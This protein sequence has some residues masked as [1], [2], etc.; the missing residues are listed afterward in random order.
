MQDSLDDSMSRISPAPIT[1]EV[2]LP[3]VGEVESK[4]RSLQQASRDKISRLEV[5]RLQQVAREKAVAD[6]VVGQLGLDPNDTFGALANRGVATYTG[7]ANGAGALASGAANEFA[8][9]NRGLVD[10]LVQQAYQREQW[11][12]ANAD[13]RKLL[14]APT[15]DRTY[16]SDAD[17]TERFANKIDARRAEIA[18][19]VAPNKEGIQPTGLPQM[20]VDGGL[21]L[22]KGAIA[23]P[24]AAVGVASMFSGGA[25]GKYL[26]DAGFRPAEAKDFVESM[27]SAELQAA[28]QSVNGAEDFWSTVDQVA[29]NPSAAGHILLESIFPMLAGGLLARGLKALGMGVK[30][31]TAA[32]EGAL[33]A[34]SSA[35]QIRGQTLDKRLSL[36]QSLAAAT[37]GVM[38]GTV[39]RLS[40]GVS[41]RLGLGDI[42]EAITKG[43]LGTSQRGVLARTG[44]ATAFESAEEGLQSTG[45]TM[46]QNFALD[47]AL[48]EGV[49]NA[50]ALG[51]VTGA[52]MGAPMGLAKGVGEAKQRYQDATKLQDEA[53]A[54]GDVTALA[55]PAARTYAPERAIA[56]LT[57]NA[58]LATTTEEAKQAHLAKADEIVGVLDKKRA[59]LGVDFRNTTLK[60]VTAKIAEM[61]ALLA[62]T[63]PAKVDKIAGYTRYLNGLQKELSLLE[64]DKTEGKRTKSLEKEIAT[65]DTQI[66]GVNTAKTQLNQ[67]VQGGTG[68]EAM[69]AGLSMPADPTDL[70]A[71]KAAQ[72]TATRTVNLAMSAPQLLDP[73]R[74]EEVAADMTNALTAPQRLVLREFSKARLEQNLL[75]S[76]GDVSRQIYEGGGGNTGIKTYQDRMAVAVRTGNQK[77]AEEQLDGLGKFEADHR[78]KAEVAAAAMAKGPGI[79]IINANGQWQIGDGSLSQSQARP[80]GALTINS[81]KL[82]SDI[83]QEAAALTASLSYLTKAYE[84]KFNAPAADASTLTGAENVTN[85]SQQGQG[86]QVQSKTPATK[87]AAPTGGTATSSEGVPATVETTGGV[88]AAGVTESAVVEAKS[89]TVNEETSVSSV[90]TDSTGVDKK[91]EITQN[92][93][94]T[95]STE[96]TADTTVETQA[97]SENSTVESDTAKTI[98]SDGKLSALQQTSPEGT[99]YKLR[100]NL[101]GDFFKQTEGR[102]GD[103][104]LRPLVAVSNFMSALRDKTVDLAD[105]L[106]EGALTGD[107]E[108]VARKT[109]I[110]QL[111]SKAASTWSKTLREN[112]AQR[113]DN[114]KEYFFRDLM[115][116][117]LITGQDGKPDLEENVKTA[118]SY[119][120]FSFITESAGK[121]F[122]NDPE[123]INALLDRDENHPVSSEETDLLGLVGDRRNTVINTLGQRAIQ[124]LGLSLKAKVGANE[125]ARLES[126]LGAH[127]WKMMVDQGLMEDTTVSG[128]EMSELIGKASTDENASFHFTRLAR[129]PESQA[130]NTAAEQIFQASRKTQGILD[131]MF[132]VESALKEPSL[133][134]V[135]AKQ[136][137]AKNTSQK[138]PSKLKEIMARQNSVANYVRQE[139]WHLIGS[140]DPGIAMQIAGAVDTD[141][142]TTHKANRLANE[143]KNEGLRRELDRFLDFVGLMDDPKAAMFFE[144]VVFKQQRVGINGNV[145]NPQT[146]KVARH[147]LYQKSWETVVRFDNEAEVKNLQLRIA[148]GLGVKA[149]KQSN[150]SS[151]ADYADIVAQPEIDA[152]VKVLQIDRKGEDLTFEQQDVL[153]AGVKAGG[154]NMASLDALVALAEMANAIVDNKPSVTVYLMGEV[155]GVTNGP[156]LSHLL[157]GAADTAKGLFGLL[158]RGGFFEEGSKHSNYNLWRGDKTEGNF[159]LYESTGKHMITAAQRL[160]TTG[161]HNAQGKKIMDGGWVSQVLGAIYTFTG[162]LSDESPQMLKKR[163]NIIK[164]PLTAMVFGSSVFSAVDSMANDFIGAIYA[165]I[166][167]MAANDLA[168]EQHRRDLIENINVLLS[169]GNAPWL[170]T[171]LTMADLMEVEFSKE[172]T[173]ALKKAF[174]STLGEAVKQTMEEDFEN[175]IGKR[176]QFNEAA[177]L[178]FEIYNAAYEA[179]RDVLIAKLVAD[180]T[181][182]ATKSGEAVHELSAEQEAQLQEQLG[183]LQPLI[184]TPLSR[185]TGELN[186]GL[187]A[188]KTSKRLSDK[189]SRASEIKF[190]KGVKGDGVWSKLKKQY[191]EKTSI[192]VNGF[193]SMEM[194]PGVAMLVMMIHS[195]DSAIMHSSIGDTEVLNVHDAKGVG[196]GGFQQAAQS[197]NASVWDVLVD[198]SPANEMVGMLSRTINGLAVLVKDDKLPLE[199]VKAVAK[200]LYTMS[201]K[202][203]IDPKDYL[204]SALKGTQQMAFEADS[205]KLEAMAMM[206]AI[207]QYA[208]QGGQYAVTK[209][210]RDAARAKMAALTA[211]VSPA[212]QASA[213]VIAEL[214]DAEFDILFKEATS[215]VVNEFAEPK[216]TP[217]PTVTSVF[218]PLGTPKIA[219]DA[220]LVEFFEANPEASFKRVLQGLLRKVS[221]DGSI[222]NP[223]F[224]TMLIKSLVKLVDPELKVKYITKDSPGDLPINGPVMGARGW[225]AINGTKQE[226]YVL[227]PEFVDSGLTTELLIHELVHAALSNIVQSTDKAVQ[228]FIA[229]LNE[230][231]KAAQTTVNG[232]A[233]LK[234]KFGDAVSNLDELLAWGMTNQEFQMEVLAKVNMQSTTLGKMVNGLQTFVANLAKL[235]GFKDVASADGLGVLIANVSAL[236]E[237]V[238]KTMPVERKAE[239]QLSLTLAMA[240]SSM[241]SVGH[242]VTAA[243]KRWFGDSKVVDVN[244]K[245]LVVYHGS[246]SDITEFSSEFGESSPAFYFSSA[247]DE[248]NQ[249][250]SRL[251][252]G[253]GEVITE[254]GNVMP[255]YL[256][257]KKPFRPTGGVYADTR[258][259]KLAVSL[260]EKIPRLKKELDAMRSVK[261]FIGLRQEQVDQ[262][263]SLG[264]DGVID[265]TVYIAFKPT[266]IKSAIGNNGA[267]DSNNPRTLAMAAPSLQAKLNTY[268][269]LDLHDALKDGKLSVNFANQVRGLLSNIVE[270]LHG[271]YGSFSASLME[272]QALSAEDVYLKAINTGEVP[273]ASQILGSGFVVPDQSMFAIEQIEATV[274]ATLESKE[275]YSTSA[276]RVLYALYTEV[277]NKIKVE[278]FHTGSPW[279]QAT[280]AEQAA[281]QALHDFI[282]KLESNKGQRS[283]YLSRFAAMGLAHEGFNKLLQVATDRSRTVASTKSFADRLQAIFEGILAF[284]N[285]KVTHTYKGQQADQKLTMLVG[286]LVDIEAKRRYKFAH[287][288]TSPVLDAIED[289]SKAVA[290]VLRTKISKMAGAPAV[291]ENRYAAVRAAGALVQTVADNRVEYF[292]DNLRTMRNSAFKGKLGV[293]ASTLGELQGPAKALQALLRAS[294]WMEGHRKDVITNTA[295]FARTG[296]ANQGKGMSTAAKA[297]ISQV[298]LRSGLHH[299]VGKFSMAE[300][301]GL[302]SNTNELNK[303]VAT[304]EAKLNSFGNAKYYF[305]EQANALGIQ[306]ATGAVRGEFEIMNAHNIANLYETAYQGKLTA[307]RTAEAKEVIE[308]LVALYALGYTAS[309]ARLEASTLIATENQR[310]DGNG[311]ESVLKL[312][313]Q[314]E[315]ESLERVFKGLPELMVHGYLPEIYDPNIEVKVANVADGKDLINL[316]YTKGEQVVL[317]RADP[318]RSIR[319]M[320]VRDGGGMGRRVTGITSWKSL[321]SKGTENHS[322]YTNTNTFTGA[323]NAAANADL[324]AS[325]KQAIADMFKPGPR[326]DL[327]KVKANHMA[328]VLN[329]RGEVVK[330]RYMMANTTKDSVLNRDNSF[331]KLLGVLAG[332]TYDKETSREQNK[333]AFTALKAQYDADYVKNPEAY[334]LVGQG[335]LTK[336]MKEIWDLLSA[337]SKADARAIWGYDGMMVKNDALNIMFGYRKASLANAFAKDPKLRSALE[338]IFVD[339][340]EWSLSQHGRVLKGMDR[341][342]ARAYA[343]IAAIKVTRGERVW[344]ELISEVKDIIVVKTGV[345]MM[346]NIY[347]NLSL[348]WLNGVPIKDILN[349]HLVAL[350]GATAYKQD[351][352]ELAQLTLLRDTGYMQGKDLEVNRR[353]ARLEDSLANNPVK[354]LIDLG[355]MPTIVE[356]LAADED[357]YSYKSALVRKV[358]KV[359]DKLNPTVVKAARV[360]YMAHDTQLYQGLS[361][362]TQ[363]SDFVARYTLY[364]HNINKRNPMSKEDA[365]QDASDAFIN[366]DIPMHQS[367]QYMDDMGL[368]PFT[369]Y[370]LRIQKVLGKL[371]M[372]NPGRVLMSMSVGQLMDL[373]PIVLESSMFGR[374][375]NNPLDVGPFKLLTV[376]DDIATIN[377]ALTIVK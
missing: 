78:S 239:K 363:L 30:L 350:R 45:E 235:L 364:Q 154:Q 265:G 372:D 341:D 147:M 335:A 332:A 234:A 258:L 262:L 229:E 11:G 238:A 291:A 318:D 343:K 368:L 246:I 157:M 43:A 259:K 323:Q 49:G 85:Q 150:D 370:F 212:T 145:I 254:G 165:S 269:T 136:D 308:V 94:K 261:S 36:K 99:P 247:T 104:T 244:G 204:L 193:E 319:H 173:K 365:I 97:N 257:I 198:F 64:E 207:D 330:W 163:R 292:M 65:L 280:T 121:P 311:V 315:K 285:T 266:Q 131:K 346:G 301:A 106:G 373:G 312:H 329:E 5:R 10:P 151:L 195:A 37:T 164:T 374:I 32:G 377:A 134:P 181:I 190:G 210:N 208:L 172:Q 58:Q 71:V 149:D 34:G 90:N 174:S 287:P 194:N 83:Q 137:T 70:V 67:L 56:A 127:V 196:V 278:D 306:V 48:T 144:H 68:V 357:I 175:Y 222:P 231:L 348:L 84:L 273:F 140:M 72:A 237:Q 355:L 102:D 236:F 138:V 289:K 294:K 272:E 206:I 211:E 161:I 177:Q 135:A 15:A 281:A 360:A 108:T 91:P 39:A 230:L 328:P 122:F 19:M 199:A 24:E 76:S 345:V 28:S 253:T 305:I 219:P 12:I 95:Q 371:F 52:A 51:M 116:F 326:R 46:L 361:R 354:E 60:G 112:L 35:E 353:I 79:Q 251:I 89:T 297:A 74:A 63:D 203:G 324:M 13:D 293:I 110:I 358:S 226:I 171:N 23:V 314:L 356:D 245:P 142:A 7:I 124:A 170:A 4:Y 75:I 66:E 185:G 256:S 3:T 369:K 155:D 336:E 29:A 17:A 160:M 82:V 182:P 8:R 119:A 277:K 59:E 27:K 156:M 111:F 31:A 57:G 243:F 302:V 130:L 276:Y 167:A 105:F 2:R 146:S 342:R 205:I 202:S 1:P 192:D 96:I 321:N 143:S 169:Q 351:S 42:D 376:L 300:I 248:A 98:A 201:E 20:A 178:S 158:N 347:S 359:T 41:G 241:A 313:K 255:V 200:A 267:Y 339:V 310:T 288:L 249:Y 344:Q 88:Q 53:I 159:D 126:A 331:D 120:A 218:G 317:D 77:Q 186:A 6:S 233:K 61:Q 133:A 117:L 113:P 189:Y 303:A 362:V 107:K 298:F 264:Y 274:R 290:D 80:N 141:P 16:L 320:Y 349:H 132:S 139:M 221:T 375:G 284:W 309:A 115:Q 279:S 9:F 232:D 109:A 240:A 123:A 128:K 81:Q 327:S 270:K 38:G 118:M 114:T 250:A 21:S 227:S 304:Y 62:N 168:T 87:D 333:T 188:S 50:A 54:S 18:T 268:S 33:M 14:N 22:L 148:E 263:T 296:F 86:A 242:T 282:F 307:A 367:L 44:G 179:M 225:F 125:M 26:E 217:S 286:Q 55:D 47:K 103:V 153:L 224:H 260:M 191:V 25:A 129:D 334:V 366:Y 180:E 183:A 101:I 340:M 337:D 214:L 93:Q 228:P 295:T 216:A 152:A 338:N 220:D 252:A 92:T 184:Y 187:R 69:L 299:L 271:P 215:D 325:R 162:D 176:K 213:E 197:L 316:G 223:K 73:V 166:E 275:A 352:A 100:L 322:G 209:N 40:G 283:D